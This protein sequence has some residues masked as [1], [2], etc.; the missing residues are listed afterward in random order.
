MYSKVQRRL[1]HKEAGGE[2]FT[3]D[4]EASGLIIT[5]AS[6]PNS[7]DVRRRN[8]W[9]PDTEAADQDR[10][11]QFLLGRH[12]IG[13]WHTHPESSPIPSL[14]DRRTTMEYLKAF[15][16]ERPQYLMVILGNLG[17]PP[18][19]TVWVA[20]QDLHTWTELEERFHT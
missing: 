2:I 16:G 18:N 8:S 7:G 14:Q 17:N 3:H 11:K 9:N 12:A 5:A 19:I 15:K 20:N 1:W 10:Q 6:G 13:L 4:V